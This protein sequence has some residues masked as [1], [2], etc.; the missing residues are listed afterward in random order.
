MTPVIITALTEDFFDD[1]LIF[2]DSL[3]RF[4]NVDLIVVPYGFGDDNFK[5]LEN[6]NVIV[7]IIDLPKILDPQRWIQWSKPFI[8]KKLIDEFDYD[9]YLWLDCDIVI[10]KDLSPIFSYIDNKFLI[11]KDDFAPKS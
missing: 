6:L 11:I 2:Y 8:I 7:K 10:L 1:F 9:N 3:I 4:N 5:K